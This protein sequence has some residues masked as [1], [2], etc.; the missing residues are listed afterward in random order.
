V[1]FRKRKCFICSFVAENCKYVIGKL[2]VTYVRING[3]RITN[4]SF[5]FQIYIAILMAHISY[6]PVN[7]KYDFIGKC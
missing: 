2:N 6:K 1:S 3:P 4:G 7:H 5:T